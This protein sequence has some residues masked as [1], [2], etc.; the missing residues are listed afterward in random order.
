MSHTSSLSKTNLLTDK[1]FR[2]RG[3]EMTRIE[4]FADAVFAF[5]VT[6]LV[7]ALEVP[8]TFEELTNAMKGF[9]AF[10]ICFA[11]LAMVWHHH[12]K[13][14][15]RYG[16]QTLWASILNCALLFVVLFYVYPLKFLFTFLVGSFTG[17]RLLPHG[18]VNAPML[19][20]QH[21]VTTLMV[22]YGL[23][24]AAVFLILLLMYRHAYHLRHELELDPLEIH[25]TKYEMINH[26]AMVGFGVISAFMA[27]VLPPRFVGIAGM[28][29]GGIGIYHWIAGTIMWKKHTKI[30]D[31]MAT[32][33]E[34]AARATQASPGS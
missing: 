13:F 31:S 7:V 11:L 18:P 27:L 15:R 1:N 4:A 8:H 2:W 34:T 21:E 17:G 19:Q 29:Y 32:E 26:A 25:M 24:F 14:F 9:G 23:G 28:F 30:A 6:L 22:I 16:L 20:A 12:V 3:G 33:A 5:A 10:A